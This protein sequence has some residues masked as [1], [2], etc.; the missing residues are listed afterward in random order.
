MTGKQFVALGVR[1]F[2]IWLAIDIL[3]GIP[4]VYAM[5]ENWSQPTS[6]GFVA[7]IAATAVVLALIATLL[8]RFPLAVA[9][10]L[11]SRQALDATVAIPA[12]E[13]IER[14]GFCLLGLWLLIQAAPRLVF[15]AVRLKLYFAP[16]STLELRPEDYASVAAHCVELAL[17]AWLLLGAKGLRGVLRWARTAGTN[18]VLI[19]SGR[20][21]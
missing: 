18:D 5:L 21:D 12:S 6:A 7:A 13:H 9:S 3:D 15:D 20:Q 17:A 11:L 4:G 2:A 14:A 16:G 19:E 10:K 8:W 1:L